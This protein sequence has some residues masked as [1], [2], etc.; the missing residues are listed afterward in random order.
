MK[1]MLQEASSVEKAV[2]LAWEAAQKPTDFS[3]KILDAGEK[4]FLGMAKRPAIISI[5][6]EPT[7]QRRS[8]SSTRGQRPPARRDSSQQRNRRPS[9]NRR[10]EQARPRSSE[11]RSKESRAPEPKAPEPKKQPAV[12]AA[13]PSAPTWVPEHADLIETWLKEMISHL[14]RES[15]VTR[16]QEGS[17][18]TLTLSAPLAD[19]PEAQKGLYSS[20]SSLLLQFLRKKHKQRLR[21]HRLSVKVAPNKK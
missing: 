19:T 12:A 21:G 4:N 7:A 8:T 2:S 15:T 11:P 14:G 13:Q 20:I 3:I 16:S 6:F 10:P 5:V 9:G 1:S 17:Q 18:L